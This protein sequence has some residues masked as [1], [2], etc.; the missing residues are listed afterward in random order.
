MNGTWI[1]RASRIK[2]AIA[3]AWAEAD[4][5]MDPVVP[6]IVPLDK[7]IA[8]FSLGADELPRLT[9]RSATT[10]LSA[11]SG[12]AIAAPE[13]A[14][15]E[16]AGYLYACPFGGAVYGYM[17]VEQTDPVERRR[18]SA[19]HELG[20]YLLHFLPTIQEEQ[21]QGLLLT[22]TEGLT[23]PSGDEDTALPQG[24]LSFTR[25]AEPK[26]MLGPADLARMEAEANQFAAELLMPE[27]ACNILFAHFGDRASPRRLATEFLVSQAAM[28]WRMA[29]LRSRSI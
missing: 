17:L 28:R 2:N 19:A 15:V 29:D 6:R 24:S 25:V 1:D 10:Y 22:M 20:H 27:A 3:L 12:Q 11:R 9:R 13:D 7:L 26:H 8:A 5:K 18:F 16:L 21:A 23:Y 4:L 14:D